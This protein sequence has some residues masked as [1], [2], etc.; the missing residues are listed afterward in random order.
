MERWQEGQLRFEC[1]VDALEC[2]APQSFV[3]RMA[4]RRKHDI[5]RLDRRLNAVVLK[6]PEISQNDPDVGLVL[7]VNAESSG[8]R[9]SALGTCGL[10]G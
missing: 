7:T 4:R 1:S 8:S 5:A 6:G 3:L 10:L 9:S 2:V